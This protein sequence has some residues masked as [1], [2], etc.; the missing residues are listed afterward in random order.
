MRLLKINGVEAD[1]DEQTSIGI[2]Y[3]AYDIKEPS[4]RKI[5]LSNSFT[6]PKTSKNCRII[7]FAGNVQSLGI[8]IYDKMECN[9]WN[10]NEKLISDAKVRIEEVSDRIKLFVYEKD[11]FWD[12]MKLV[13]WDD[14]LDEFITW[15]QEEKSLPSATN[16]FLGNLGVFLNPYINPTEGI[17]L[18]FYFGN[19]ALHEPLGEGTGFLED[20]T[21][22]WLKYF[23]DTDLV[24]SKGG[25]FCIFCKTIFEFI[26]YK[27][28]VNF[29]IGTPDILG[30]IW[31]DPYA[32]A[33]YVPARDIDVRFHYSGP[34]IDG[35]YFEKAQSGI[36]APEEDTKDKDGKTLGEFVTSFFQHF[37]I[38]K[39]EFFIGTER[40]IRLARF[41][42]IK[43]LAEVVNFSGN[44]VLDKVKFRPK[45]EGYN[46]SNLI[47]FSDIFPE[48]ADTIGQKVLT[49]L[50]KNLDAVQDLFTIDAY[51]PNFIAINAGVVPNLAI[52]DSFKTFEFFISE[53]SSAD[54]ITIS[55]SDNTLLPQTATF[56]LQKPAIYSLA[57][58]YTFLDEII[59]Y[60]KFYEIEK[61]LS[62]KDVKDIVF[63]R[64]Y[65]IRELNG[66]FFI[67]KISG[68]NP[69]KSN[70]PTKIELIRVSN[71]VPKPITFYDIDFYSDGTE[72]VFVD[73][74][75]DYFI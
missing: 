8:E 56:N 14:F 45:I 49:C 54:L 7:G 26:E 59:K 60:P 62:L 34:A 13:S 15:M 18:P 27:Y 16:P 63:F 31:D 68:F 19:L 21:N 70:A 24:P 37:N 32:I 71:K 4:K 17:I 40:V 3:Q 39:D 65:Y 67:N 46:Q 61:W 74:T 22:I 35:F 44:L 72:D 53:G 10:D 33:T 75:G 66:S 55:V 42:N 47:K 29:L 48:G 5:K 64:Q 43:D 12:E 20:Q 58:E 11:D 69:D 38:I 30:N 6:I 2:T 28:D 36:F 50:N 52:A 25:H 23:S 57:G 9:Y 41:D 51:V 1:L 73:G